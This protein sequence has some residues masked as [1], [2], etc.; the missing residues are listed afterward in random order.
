MPDVTMCHG[1]NCPVSHR[2]Y[3]AI[4]SPGLMQSYSNF[5][6]IRQESVP[7]NYFWDVSHDEIADNGFSLIT[8]KED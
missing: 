4:A 3:R 2:C 1:K 8:P 7:C 6:E 5:D